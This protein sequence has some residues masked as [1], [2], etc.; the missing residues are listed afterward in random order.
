V[1]NK[2]MEQPGNNDGD[3]SLLCLNV[4]EEQKEVIVQLFNHYDWTFHE[5]ALAASENTDV[6]IEREEEEQNDD[7]S[8][9]EDLFVPGYVINQDT[10]AEVCQ[11]CLC[12]PCIT[13]DSNKQAWW[14]NK[15]V[16][17][18]GRNSGLRKIAYRKFWTML[19]HR[20]VWISPI[21]MAIKV[22]AMGHDPQRKQ[23]VY[24]RRDI[25][26]DCVLNK[27]RSWYPNPLTMPYMGHLWG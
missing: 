15:S 22:Q 14:C 18:H 2:N 16:D 27:V 11:Q 8:H 1:K 23:Y 25:M 21:Y 6:S 10:E 5:V 9:N 20:Q 12:Q 24:H 17:P 3:K 26:P 4:T 7:G 13:S 19:H